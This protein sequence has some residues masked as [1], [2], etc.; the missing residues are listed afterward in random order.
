MAIKLEYISS[1]YTLHARSLLANPV[2]L[3]IMNLK[4]IITFISFLVTVGVTQG[5]IA[6]FIILTCYICNNQQ[7][8]WL[9]AYYICLDNILFDLQKYTLLLYILNFRS[10]IFWLSRIRSCCWLLLWWL[11]IC[12][13]PIWWLPIWW[14]PLWWLPLWWLPVIWLLH[15]GISEVSSLF[16]LNIYH[17]KIRAFVCIKNVCFLLILYLIWS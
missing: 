4:L 3:E 14:L 16:F 13:L 6:Y 17:D 15:D 8:L 1:K 9:I 10:R 11:R 12:W 2:T 5:T 7:R